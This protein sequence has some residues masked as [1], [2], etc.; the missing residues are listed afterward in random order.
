MKESPW[1]LN[2]LPAE[3]PYFGQVAQDRLLRIL[4]R[5][6]PSSALRCDD[7]SEL[8]FS[9]PIAIVACCWFWSLRLLLIQTNEFLDDA[10]FKGGKQILVRLAALCLI[11]ILRLGCQSVFLFD[12]LFGLLNVCDNPIP[13]AFAASRV[14]EVQVNDHFVNGADC[15]AF[16][17]CRIWSSNGIAITVLSRTR[18]SNVPPGS[19]GAGLGFFSSAFASS[20]VVRN[21]ATCL[22]VT[23]VPVL[24]LNAVRLSE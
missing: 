18:G 11:D 5:R 17:S 12:G 3:K 22:P 7:A 23:R 24:S 2:S 14:F 4:P 8:S 13:R 16:V 6:L 19:G 15:A 10:T 9:S 21:A 20:H 1:R